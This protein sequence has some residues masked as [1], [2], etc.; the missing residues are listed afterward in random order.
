MLD[1]FSIS[2]FSLGYIPMFAIF[3]ADGIARVARE[4]AAVE[5]LIGGAFALAFAVWAFPSFADVRR[6][7]APTVLGV[8]AIDSLDPRRDDLFVGVAMHPF[9]QV[10]APDRTYV[11]VRR[12]H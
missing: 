4:R 1:R 12:E 8:R 5:A 2:P 10:L 7:D 11:K 6:S 3:A 9:M